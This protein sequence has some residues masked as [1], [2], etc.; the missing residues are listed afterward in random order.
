LG[1]NPDTDL[2]EPR[3]C[4]VTVLFCDLR[5]FSQ[6]AEEAA[7]NLLGLLERVSRAFEV[8]R[9]EILKYGGVPCDFQG[10]AALGFWGWP[11]ASDEA[12]L[13]AC[14]AALG[15]RAAFAAT[16]RTPDHPL[17]NFQM[18]IGIAH[19]WAVAGKIGA[20]EQVK[21]TVFGPVVNLASRLEAMTKQ[22]R[23]PILLDEA[24]AEFARKR[25]GP[26]QGR[27]RRLARV[28][29]YG[30]EKP[31]DVSEL[32]PSASDYPELTAEHVRQYEA[33]V[34]HFVHGRWEE[35][36]ECLHGMPAGDRA[37]DFLAMLIAQHNRVAPPDWDGVVRLATK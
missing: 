26:E 32:L 20:A 18:G 21:V 2:L 34:E 37:Q 36:Y 25:L 28:L 23:V 19:G 16:R 35:A 30:L 12:P 9:K 31:L 11:F 3:E 10:D 29:P 22:L 27:V 7:G 8:M 33:G 15:I 5:G 1:D 4:N 14:R 6:R 17:A 13:N 24:T